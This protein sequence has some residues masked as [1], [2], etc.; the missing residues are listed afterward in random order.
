[1]ES[2]TSMSEYFVAANT[3]TSFT[4]LAESSSNSFGTLTNSTSNNNDNANPINDS[5]GLMNNTLPNLRRPSSP[6]PTDQLGHLSPV[7]NNHNQ[8][9][10]D[11]GNSLDSSPMQAS[12][13]HFQTHINRNQSRSS[14]YRSNRNYSSTMQTQPISQPTRAQI[15][16]HCYIEQLDACAEMPTYQPTLTDND[17]FKTANPSD[18]TKA[19]T[20]NQDLNILKTGSINNQSSHMLQSKLA[21]ESI[22]SCNRSNLNLSRLNDSSLFD[23]DMDPTKDIGCVENLDQLGSDSPLSIHPPAN[24]SHISG[25]N[26]YHQPSDLCGDAPDVP[27]MVPC[28]SNDNQSLQS[29][30]ETYVIISSNVLFIDLVRTVMQQLGYTPMEQLNAK[31]KYRLR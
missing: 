18:S 9:S 30:R 20:S 25:N 10:F 22:T 4:D 11:S 1:M 24:E 8:R 6:I 3:R 19:S 15:P 23:N 29:T 5:V 28:Y 31:G 27:S 14:P 26:G 7:P 13:T 21:L 17:L 16:V 2:I 12:Q